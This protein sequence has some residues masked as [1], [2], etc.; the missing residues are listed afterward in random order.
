MDNNMSDYYQVLQYLKETRV[1]REYPYEFKDLTQ[2]NLSNPNTTVELT[3]DNISNHEN[4]I[5]LTSIEKDDTLIIRLNKPRSYTEVNNFELNLLNVNGS[6]QPDDLTIELSNSPIG[7]PVRETLTP[8]PDTTTITSNTHGT[9]IYD[10]FKNNTAVLKHNRPLSD[11]Q[12]IKITFNKNIADL[13]I[14]ET[15]FRTTNY[16]L[17]LEDI[18][19]N[20]EAGKDYVRM[21]LYLA[22]TEDIPD[23]IDYLSYK[24]AAAYAW[25]TQWE[26]EGKAMNDGTVNGENYAARL[27]EQIDAAIAKYVE[28]NPLNVDDS[29]N[30]E[31]ISYTWL[32]G[33]HR[34]PYRP[35]RTIHNLRR[36]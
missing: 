10:V 35:N 5:H 34:R 15:V 29:I 17:T 18:D 33:I 28:A 12:S 8:N 30:T 16:H 2:L 1:D 19:Y 6:L 32:E 7:I 13:Y 27:F 20:I 23:L 26:N 14:S 4:S 11:T 3:E 25:L 31:M 24:A 9:L 21:Q 22:E 36:W